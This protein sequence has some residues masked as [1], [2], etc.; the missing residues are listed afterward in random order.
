MPAEPQRLR[1]GG[2]SAVWRADGRE[3][4]Y[5]DALANIVAVPVTMSGTTLALGAPRPLLHVELKEGGIQSACEES[6]GTP[7]AG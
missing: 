2:I 4:Y 5:L 3:I 1:D 7:C 6:E